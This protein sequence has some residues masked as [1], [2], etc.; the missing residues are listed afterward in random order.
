MPNFADP[1]YIMME[2]DAFLRTYNKTGSRAALAQANQSQYKLDKLRKEM[3]AQEQVE[4]P[5]RGRP[6]KVEA[7]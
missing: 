3:A 1:K 6:R 5:K 7:V 2:R 4:K